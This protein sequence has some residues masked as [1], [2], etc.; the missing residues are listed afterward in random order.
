MTTG[1]TGDTAVTTTN[2]THDEGANPS[3]DALVAE[4]KKSRRD[5]SGAEVA[6]HVADLPAHLERL[7]EGTLPDIAAEDQTGGAALHRDTRLVDHV[8]FALHLAAAEEHQ[9]APGGLD[10]H[11][12][13][14]L[15]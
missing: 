12:H 3:A 10:H 5:R 4:V 2:R 14:F 7:I 9:R 15:A 13:R 6:N 1:Q 11:A 8:A